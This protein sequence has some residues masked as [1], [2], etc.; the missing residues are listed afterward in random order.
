MEAKYH[1]ITDLQCRVLHFGKEIAVASPK[2]DCLINLLKGRHLLSFVSTENELDNYIITFEVPD[3]DTEDFIKVSLLPYKLERLSKED[4]E[5]KSQ[6]LIRREQLKR[7]REEEL[8]IRRAREVETRKK[9]QRDRLSNAIEKL[10][11]GYKITV[12]ESCNA[13]KYAIDIAKHLFED[14]RDSDCIIEDYKYSVRDCSGDISLGVKSPG[15]YSKSFDSILGSSEL[16]KFE[17]LGSK[18]YYKDQFIFK[19]YK[20]MCPVEGTN[21][22]YGYLNY[23][24]NVVIDF[25]FEKAWPFAYDRAVVEYDILTHPTIKPIYDNVDSDIQVEFRYRRLVTAV[26]NCKG[27][28]V[29]F[30]PSYDRKYLAPVFQQ[31]LL[32]EYYEYRAYI[33]SIPSPSIAVYDIDGHVIMNKRDVPSLRGQLYIRN[34]VVWGVGMHYRRLINLEGEICELKEG[35]Y[36]ELL[37]SLDVFDN[38]IPILTKN[39][40]VIWINDRGDQI[41]KMGYPSTR[42][43]L[44]N[45]RRNK[46]TEFLLKLNYRL[47]VSKE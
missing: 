9:E 29:F 2:E 6:D 37:S 7:K 43:E 4:E 21:G 5:R 38:A 30:L 27:E 33:R 14:Y 42:E 1:I 19:Y 25:I 13:T 17:W 31:G 23:D 18:S 11:K 39:D 46:E 10:T 28:F 22:K 3:N 40:E 34:N 47:E 26:I 24:G 45:Y 16:S 35:E 36:L 12:N 15:K 32:V 20:G 8:L 44:R 41:P